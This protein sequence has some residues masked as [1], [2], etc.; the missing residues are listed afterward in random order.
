[1][2]GWLAS[3]GPVVRVR[4]LARPNRYLAVV[5]D[6]GGRRLEAHLPNPGRMEEL[7]LPGLTTGWMVPAP[8]GRSR[9]TA[10]TLVAVRHGRSTVSI[11]PGLSTRLVGRA[12][13]GCGLPGVPRGPWVP[14]VRVG[15]H[16]MDFGLP[17]PTDR[18]WRALLEVK[19]SNLRVGRTA[20]F[21]D[22]PTERGRR[23][24]DLLARHARGGRRSDVVFVVQ[25]NDV[26]EFRPNARLDPAFAASLRRAASA[27]VRLHA[28]TLRVR[29]G[30]AA[31]GR[32]LPV[33]LREVVGRARHQPI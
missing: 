27:G 30:R 10:W 3:P 23:H 13:A 18:P 20:F 19:S 2:N 26:D 15:R 4:F 28:L 17:G 22:A 25:R 32:S 31:L 29:P 24:L 5:R 6:G 9:R 33:V 11:D 1:M 12:L 16:R 14:E 8:P 21:P 7:L